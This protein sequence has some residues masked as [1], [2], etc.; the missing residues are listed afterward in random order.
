MSTLKF[1]RIIFFFEGTSESSYH[2]FSIT[3][4]KGCRTAFYVSTSLLL[5][6]LFFFRKK[7]NFFKNSFD[8]D[9]KNFGRFGTKF[10]QNYQNCILRVLVKFTGETFQKFI[11]VFHFFY[12]CAKK[13]EL[14]MKTFPQSVKIVSYVWTATTRQKMWFSNVSNY[15]IFRGFSQSFSERLVKT[16]FYLF[17]ANLWAFD[18]YSMKKLYLKILRNVGENLQTVGKKLGGGLTGEHASCAKEAFSLTYFFWKECFFLQEV[19]EFELKNINSLMKITGSLTQN[20][21]L[22]VHVII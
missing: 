6:K 2:F 19:W 3:L 21:F 11:T 18:N 10:Q 15:Y 7:I 4:R 16:A 17:T 12:S 14:S 9:R 22:S 5:V 13:F 8:F 20:C 1:S